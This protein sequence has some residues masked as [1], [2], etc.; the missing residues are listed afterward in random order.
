MKLSQEAGVSS[1]MLVVLRSQA[2]HQR[3]K[4][5]LKAFRARTLHTVLVSVS[6]EG[7]KVPVLVVEDIVQ[8]LEK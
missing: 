6:L 5:A 1:G 8:G 7:S 2:P 4:M 3:Q